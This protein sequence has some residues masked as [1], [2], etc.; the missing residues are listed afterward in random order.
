MSKTHKKL[1]EPTCRIFIGIQLDETTQE[2]LNKLT[3]AIKRKQDAASITSTR[4]ITRQNRH[5]TLCFLGQLPIE[6]IPLLKTGLTSI[7]EATT[8]LKTNFFKLG[9]FPGNDAHLIAAEVVATQQLEALHESIKQLAKRLSLPAESR[10]YR[11]H[12][13]LCRSGKQF[14]WFS[15]LKL[16]HP[17]TLN[18]ITLYQSQPSQY[19]SRYSPL[20]TTTLRPLKN[21]NAQL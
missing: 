16:E 17:L 2:F 15:P 6:V 7:A 11:P 14:Q 1:L 3:V 13:T 12:I 8:E 19:G 9:T 5:I 4:W 20:Q 21:S 10:R 18:N